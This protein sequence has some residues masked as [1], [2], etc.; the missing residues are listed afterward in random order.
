M[1]EP[2]EMD[3]RRP[4]SLPGK[5]DYRHM[6]ELG[7]ATRKTHAN[8]IAMP[9]DT[10]SRQSSIPV[11]ERPPA[12]R[13]LPR[14]GQS[15]DRP[16]PYV[17]FRSS[18]PMCRWLQWARP[19][20]L[21]SI[22]RRASPT[23]RFPA[24]DD[25]RH[26]VPRPCMLDKPVRRNTHWMALVARWG[27]GRCWNGGSHIQSGSFPPFCRLPPP[28]AIRPRT[29]LF[30]RSRASAVMDGI[31]WASRPLSR[32]A[33]PHRAR[34]SPWRVC[35]RMLTYL[36]GRGICIKKFVASCKGRAAPTSSFDARFPDESYLRY[37]ARPSSSGFRRELL[38]LRHPCNGL[39]RPRSRVTTANRARLP[40]H[41]DAVLRDE[42]TSD[43]LFRRKD[44]APS[45][46]R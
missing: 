14:S 21:P 31:R 28:R 2:I 44:R 13:V 25:P 12:G 41:A 24:G 1:T 33:A 45:C 43:W 11:K 15:A 36:S 35:G 40:G 6:G 5:I 22:R 8:L 29:R 37:Q 3:L 10:H 7:P 38:S 46:G 4:P 19:A 27:A 34:G 16:I 18:A 39:F 42:L 17:R 26:G 9:R 23:A 20:P 32:N 30:H